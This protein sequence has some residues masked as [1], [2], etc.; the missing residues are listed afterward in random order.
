MFLPRLTPLLCCA[1]LGL[2]LAGDA[3][4]QGKPPSNASS[5]F[6]GVSTST[7]WSDLTPAQRTALAPLARNWSQLTE[8]HQRK[9][10]A[11]AE[12]FSRMTPAEQAKLHSRMA[13]WVALSPQQRTEARLNFAESQQ[14]SPD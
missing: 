3:L 14:V 12:N 5:S 9:W 6:R 11:L 10:I 2:G 1:A 8:G 13:G 7:A 4:A